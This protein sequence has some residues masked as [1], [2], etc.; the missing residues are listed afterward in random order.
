MI[1]GV[2]QQKEHKNFY[3]VPSLG[4]KRYLS[5]L[6]YAEMMIGN[7]SSGTTEGPALHIPTVDIGDRQQGRYFAGKCCAL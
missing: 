7:S 4:V 2:K 5:A 6:K 1:C 3:V